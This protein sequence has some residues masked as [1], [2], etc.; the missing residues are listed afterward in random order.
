MD[1]FNEI[2]NCSF[3]SKSSVCFKQLI[4]SEVEFINNNKT[5][6]LYRAG[7][8][9]CK[10]KAYASNVLYIA[11]GLVKVYLESPKDLIINLK[12]LKASEYIGLSSIYGDN[13]YHYSAVALVDTTICMINK[14][15]FR[16]V[17]ID[18]GNFASEIIQ[19]Y[20][21]QETHLFNRI[22]S[23]GHK[24]M[25]G[26][27]ADVL[28]TLCDESYDPDVLFENLTRKDIADFACISTES[29]VR[30]LTE[31]K[32]EGLVELEGKK[33]KILDRKRLIEISRYG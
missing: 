22:K 15:S 10:E 8:N 11:E 1:T 2:V 21:G 29:T 13:I 4:P 12:I 7:E 31:L 24:Q 16:K 28:L 20:C 23:L 33:I 25:H 30:L 6:I 26:R 5:Q 17:L 27:L 14:D 19:W 32:N 3:C 9:I 18:N